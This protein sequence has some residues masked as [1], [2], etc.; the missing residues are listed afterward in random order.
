MS[1]LVAS[2]HMMIATTT[3]E[4]ECLM[5]V[6][7]YAAHTLTQLVRPIGNQFRTTKNRMQKKEHKNAIHIYTLL[8]SVNSIQSY[9]FKFHCK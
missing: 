1:P 7:T 5:N 6:T 2:H 8:K 9:M 4:E 3:K